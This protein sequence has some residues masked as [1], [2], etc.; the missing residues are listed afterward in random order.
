MYALLK[1]DVLSTIRGILLCVEHT[2]KNSQLN[3]L[4]LDQEVHKKYYEYSLK[5]KN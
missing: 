1:I 5:T 2:L 3:V 4:E